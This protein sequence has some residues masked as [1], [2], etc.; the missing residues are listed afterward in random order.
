MIRRPAVGS[1]RTQRSG[2]TDSPRAS[3]ETRP[4][5]AARDDRR[6][7]DRSSST[8]PPLPVRDLATRA[9]NPTVD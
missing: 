9:A 4:A 2:L 5:P 6:G 7:I 8:P 1:Q 3:T